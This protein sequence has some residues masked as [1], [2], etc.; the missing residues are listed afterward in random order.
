[1]RPK[2]VLFTGLSMIN[3]ALK[4]TGYLI[5]PVW[6]LLAG[7]CI[8]FEDYSNDPQGNLDAL[9]KIM[10]EHYCFFSEKQVDW[11]EIYREYSARIS[12]NMGNEALF[13]LLNDMLKELRDGHVNLN[14]SFD[15]G[16]YDAW[17]YDSAANFNL[18]LI[19]KQYLGRD[20]SIASGLKYKV[21]ESNIGYIY[22]ESFSKAIGEG[23]LDY[24]IKRFEACHGIIIDIRDNGGGA[25]TN[26]DILASRFTNEKVLTGYI[27]HKTGTGHNDFSEPYPRYI[28]PSTR[29]RFQKPVVVLTNRK[30]YSAANDFANTMKQLK[31]VRL[32]GSMTGGG[33]GFPLS[34]ELPIGWSVRFSASPQLDPNKQS[35]EPGVAPHQYVCM[36]DK[37]L[38]TATS[39][40]VIEAAIDYIK[41]LEGYK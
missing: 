12:P 23:N 15:V 3:Y 33:G 10:D 21:L 18:K 38:Q 26:V 13:Y 19:E 40:S 4:R 20:Y 36:T 39:D 14:A 28:E 41:E 34:S 31:N 17:Y 2:R 1:M 22:Y 30:C 24:V 6:L 35:I 8:S 5:L 29:L 11:D 16:R 9:W 7:S 27:R 37:Y 32:I 25:L